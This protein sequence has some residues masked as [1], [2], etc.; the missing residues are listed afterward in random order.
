MP[1]STWIFLYCSS[2][3]FGP[4]APPGACALPAACAFATSITAP[5]VTRKAINPK[6]NASF[7]FIDESKKCRN[8]KYRISAISA[9]LLRELRDSSFTHH[10]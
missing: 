9:A 3:F 8:K 5:P 4:A 1:F 2:A 7:L 10:G 6:A